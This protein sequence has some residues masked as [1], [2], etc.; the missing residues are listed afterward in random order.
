M[1]RRRLKAP[2][3]LAGQPLSSTTTIHD[4]RATGLPPNAVV[5]EQVAQDPAGDQ[6][7]VLVA[8]RDDPLGRLFVRRQIDAAQLHGGRAWQECYERTQLW[9]SGGIAD[10]VDG[11]GKASDPF[12]R[13]A[14][15]SAMVLKCA[16]RLG[17][18]GNGLVR[19]FLGERRFMAQIAVSRGLDPHPDSRD[20]AYLGRRLRECLNT[21]AKV[22]GYA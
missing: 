21:L 7:R 3:T 5:A 16:E 1:A 6:T 20:M 15:A 12:V 14:D 9:P 13:I 18:Q 8:I 10:P 22:F 11:G 2:I 17:E 4:R 19:D